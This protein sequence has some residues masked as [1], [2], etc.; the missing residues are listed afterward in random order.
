MFLRQSL[1]VIFER[2]QNGSSPPGILLAPGFLPQVGRL[3]SVFSFIGPK[4]IS[5]SKPV[6]FAL[7]LAKLSAV[8]FRQPTTN[9]DY[10]T[11][12]TIGRQKKNLM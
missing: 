11:E 8:T 10:V 6:L 3:W 12:L 4:K 1:Y 2:F 7:G 5:I 9:G